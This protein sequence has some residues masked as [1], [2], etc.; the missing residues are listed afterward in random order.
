MGV[1]ED[2]ALLK[3]AEKGRLEAVKSALDAGADVNAADAKGRT[4]VALAVSASSVSCTH[5]I[6]ARGADPNIPD[7]NKEFPIHIAACFQVTD[8]LRILVDSGS[9]NLESQNKD[10]NTAL[11]KAAYGGCV[12]CVMYLTSKG[13]DS[14]AQ[15]NKYEIPAALARKKNHKGVLAVMKAAQLREKSG[16]RPV[17]QIIHADNG[18]PLE[19][20]RFARS[21][22]ELEAP[23]GQTAEADDKPAEESSGGP[24]PPPPGGGPPPPPSGGGPPPPPGGAPNL[25]NQ[26]KPAGGG[27]GL[28]GI[29]QVKLK[30]SEG[31]QESKPAG[32]GGGGGGG[33]VGGMMAEMMAKRNKMAKKKEEEGP[34]FTTP[35]LKQ[36]EEDFM[37]LLKNDISSWKKDICTSLAA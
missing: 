10:G 33:G 8:T 2:K 19:P 27:G 16:T 31:P 1:K 15:N 18:M 26:N 30:K 7:K 5:E 17:S 37:F 23:E 9:V 20:V 13:A 32:G 6:L 14:K 28:A 12:D 34:T 4:A 11:H 22:S 21:P 3:A 24:P 35:Q 29:G 36:F 25:A